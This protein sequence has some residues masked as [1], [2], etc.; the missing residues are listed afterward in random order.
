MLK[1]CFDDIAEVKNSFWI[2]PSINKTIIFLKIR[3]GYGKTLKIIFKKVDEDFK[4][5]IVVAFSEVLDKREKDEN[6][7]YPCSIRHGS[8][9]HNL[10]VPTDCQVALSFQ[11]FPW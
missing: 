4:I 10:S 1:P 9:K 2:K 11:I 6:S 8:K 5:T 3:F 7:V